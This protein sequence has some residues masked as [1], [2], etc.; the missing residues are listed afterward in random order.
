MKLKILLTGTILILT[1]VMIAAGADIAGKWVVERQGP[2]GVQETV[3]NFMVNGGVLTGTVSGGRGGDAEIREGKIEGDNIS[4][5]AVSTAGGTEMSTQ[6]RG[7]I[8]GDEIR[9]TIERQGAPDAQR[10][11]GQGVAGASGGQRGGGQAG[12]GSASK[13][14]PDV[15]AVPK[16]KPES[17]GGAPKT[18]P[19]GG[20]GSQE[21]IAKRA[22]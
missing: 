12:S 17:G 13:S 19:G 6:Y 4:F 7:K 1:M 14:K 8:S 18:K 15:G 3:F 21:L 2:Q 16:S 11:G 9:F 10:G 22:K 20:G 5:A